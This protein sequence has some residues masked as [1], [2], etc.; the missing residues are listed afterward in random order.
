MRNEA[1]IRR[2]GLNPEEAGILCLDFILSK[3]PLKDMC[4]V[5]FWLE[6]DI[7]RFKILIIFLKLC[8]GMD[9]WEWLYR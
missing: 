8:C 9:W 6:N 3:E 4:F 5:L 2:A 7:T 1:R